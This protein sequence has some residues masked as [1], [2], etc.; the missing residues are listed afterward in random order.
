MVVSFETDI[1]YSESAYILSIFKCFIRV[2]SQFREKHPVIPIEKC[3]SLLIPKNAIMLQHLIICNYCSVNVSSDRLREV[4]K[5][6][7]T[8]SS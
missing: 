3:P 8:L 2:K 1:P 6:V 7:S 4:N 5:E